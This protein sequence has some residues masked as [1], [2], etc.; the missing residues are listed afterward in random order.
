[1]NIQWFPGHMTK[2]RRQMAEHSKLVDAVCEVLDVRIPLASR[3]PDLD[4]LTL[5][6][7]RL[8]VLNRAD[9][10]DG[11]ASK[12][13][14]R[15]F[16]TGGTPVVLTDSQRGTGVNRIAPVLRTLLK[17]KWAL[18]A[19]KGQAGRCMR[20]MIVGIPNVGK[21]SLIN[22]LTGRRAA[23]VEDRPGV[24]RGHQWYKVDEG[25][26]LLDTPGILWPKIEDPEVGLMLAYTGA[27][28]DAVIDIETLAA[29]LLELLLEKYPA[30]L[31]QRYKI[32]AMQA[33]GWQ[34]LEHIARKRGFLQ[35]GGVVDI[36]RMAVILLD[37]FRAGKL[38]RVTLELP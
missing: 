31:T 9:Q 36:E 32:Q 6:R 34:L 5:N 7:P 19:Q 18:L 3:N 11:E 4:E 33:P 30:M 37:E 8:I 15:H 28:K 12:A 21:S 10:A 14:A 24:T 25:L 26:E 2:T 13:W 16:T 23:P 17:E 22:R 1:M 38:G 20:V 27:V 35:P 29:H